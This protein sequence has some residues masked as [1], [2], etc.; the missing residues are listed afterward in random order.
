MAAARGCGSQGA[1]KHARQEAAHNY[2]PP[3]NLAVLSPHFLGR[4]IVVHTQLLVWVELEG[5]QDA[6][7]LALALRI[8][9]VRVEFLHRD[10]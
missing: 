4:R 9:Q 7:H 3:T 1:L 8:L 6:V 5:G 2:Q 10:I